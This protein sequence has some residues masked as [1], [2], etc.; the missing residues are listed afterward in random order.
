MITLLCRDCSFTWGLAG[1]VAGNH[2]LEAPIHFPHPV[3]PNEHKIP[4]STK[5]LELSSP[6][7]SKGT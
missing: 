2:V 1:K 7:F 5:V 6:L 3:K 4:L